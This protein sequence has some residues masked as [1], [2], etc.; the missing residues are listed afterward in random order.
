MWV[1]FHD[2]YYRDGSILTVVRY[3]E[4]KGWTRDILGKYR[5][6]NGEPCALKSDDKRRDEDPSTWWA[7]ERL[8]ALRED[9]VGRLM[10]KNSTRCV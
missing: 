3:R 5:R 8:V 6:I 4:G 2:Y 1:N 9:L 7:A 10:A